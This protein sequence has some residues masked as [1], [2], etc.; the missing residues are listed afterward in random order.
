MRRS[1]ITNLI[2][3]GWPSLAS[4]RAIRFRIHLWAYSQAKDHHIRLWA[5]LSLQ[6]SCSARNQFTFWLL[7]ICRMKVVNDSWKLL[8]TTSYLHDCP[9]KDGWY[10]WINSLQAIAIKICTIEL[11]RKAFADLPNCMQSLQDFNIPNVSLP[12]AGCHPSSWSY[13]LREFE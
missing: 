9:C 10:R 2:S 3:G 7:K 1:T 12:I 8:Q 13:C 11:G 6:Q 4:H 5:L